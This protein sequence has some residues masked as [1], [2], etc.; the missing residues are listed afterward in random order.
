MDASSLAVFLWVS[1]LLT[2]SPGPD[3]ILVVTRGVTMGRKAA[4]TSATGACVGLVCHSLLAAAGLS[5]ILARSSE[6]YSV[7]KYAGAA[8]LLYLGVQSIRHRGE[9]ILPNRTRALGLRKVFGQALATNLLNPKIV[10]F[11][12]AYLPQFANPSAGNLSWQ[13]L[14]LGLTF[15]LL[16]WLILSVVAYF[17]GN[18]GVWLRRRPGI[19]RGLEWTTGGVFIALGLRLALPERR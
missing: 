19:S 6:A 12:L 16:G 5:A 10:I 13:L 17:S 11:F 1:A 18:L 8:Y 2:F 4:W 7:V 3:N 9:L 14:G 15:S